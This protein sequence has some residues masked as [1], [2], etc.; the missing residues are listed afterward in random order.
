MYTIK[1]ERLKII[2]L[3]HQLLK[4]Y[5][6]DRA[7]MERRLGLNL[8]AMQISA[9]YKAEL[10]DALLNFWLPQTLA[11][12]NKYQWFTTWEVILKLTNTSIGAIG[13]AGYPNERGESEIGYVIDEQQQRKGYAAEALQAMT[14]WFFSH[15]DAKAIIANVPTDNTPSQKVLEKCNFTCFYKNDGLLKY[16]RRSC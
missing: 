15:D 9:T 12:P 8:S 1:T 16:R 4:L 11:D 2:P 3:T 6:A 10:Q 7:A 5:L 14:K 13:F